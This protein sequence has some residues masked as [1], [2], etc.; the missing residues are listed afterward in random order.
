MNDMDLLAS[1]RADVPEFPVSPETE[2]RF[3]AAL[4]IMD[5]GDLCEQPVLVVQDRRIL[6]KKPLRNLGLLFADSAWHNAV[7][8][9]AD[10][11]ANR[12]VKVVV[13]IL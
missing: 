13:I 12:S 11:S 4:S 6:L 10:V 2:H 7:G 8:F 3:H 9:S 5:R 1:F